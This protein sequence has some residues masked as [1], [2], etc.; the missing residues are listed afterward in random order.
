MLMEELRDSFLQSK[1]NI[2]DTTRRNYL[3]NFNQLLIYWNECLGNVDVETIDIEPLRETFL[4]YLYSKKVSRV[5][6][7]EGYAKGYVVFY[8]LKAFLK[9]LY[10]F[11]ARD[12]IVRQL[13]EKKLEV[14][15]IRPLT[16]EETN[17]LLALLNEIDAQHSVRQNKKG[18]KQEHITNP[19]RDRAIIKTFFSTGLRASELCK[20]KVKDILFEQGIG[21]IKGKGRRRKKDTFYFL[22]N[23]HEELRQWLGQRISDPD[24]FIFL[25]NKQRPFTY[26]NLWRLMKNL[27]ESSEFDFRC[28]TFRHSVGVYLINNGWTPEGVRKFLRHRDISTTGIYLRQRGE[29][30]VLRAIRSLGRWR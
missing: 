9:C 14:P 6:P 18:R 11:L 27:S 22:F 5:R 30:D 19:D 3:W 1:T 26:F 8:R 25:D 28:H 24:N 16:L 2:A 4:P 15:E 7:A 21:K 12:D 17:A 29:V 13:A 23:Y 10:R 20:L